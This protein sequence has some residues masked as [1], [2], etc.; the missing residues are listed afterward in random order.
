MAE[1][2]GALTTEEL[3]L[4]VAEKMSMASYDSNGLEY[5]TTDQYQL[6]TFLRIINNGIRMFMNT[7]P[8]PSGKWNWMKRDATVLFVPAGDGGDNIASDAARYMLAV[9]FNGQVAG[10]IKYVASTGHSTNI[11]WCHPS[12]IDDFRS[13]AISTGYP[14]RAALKPYSPTGPSLGASRR[15]EVIFDPQPS[16]AHTVTF[17]YIVYFDKLDAVTGTAT[18]GDATTLTATGVSAR[19]PNDYF[20]GWTCKITS[21][22]GECSYAVVTDYVQSTNVWTVGDW[23]DMEGAGGGTDPGVGSTFLLTPAYN[24]HPAGHAYDDVIFSA[25]LARVA[26]EDE[27]AISDQHWIDD[28]NSRALPEAYKHD[29]LSQPRKLGNILDRTNRHVRQWSNVTYNGA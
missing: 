13:Q 2:T 11:D 20:N 16:A 22:T 26:M 5:V 14:T 7:P 27:D 24:T 18:A 12:G 3:L 21:G 9:D 17:P 25:C 29:A 28:Y 19:Y 15:W 10:D 6:N 8:K 1:P 23:L 4:R